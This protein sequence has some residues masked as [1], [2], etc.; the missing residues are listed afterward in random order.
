MSTKRKTA[1]DELKVILGEIQEEKRIKH[2]IEAEK[3]EE[4]FT[5]LLAEFVQRLKTA[6]ENKQRRLTLEPKFKPIRG[7]IQTKSHL[8]V[9]YEDYN[10]IVTW[11]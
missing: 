1:E 10:T 2:Q 4:K 11:E 9:H 7:Y 3:K 8:Y 5:N 6:R